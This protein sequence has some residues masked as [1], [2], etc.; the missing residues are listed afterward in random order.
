MLAKPIHDL[1]PTVSCHMRT[2]VALTVSLIL[3]ACEPSSKAAEPGSASAAQLAP[4]PAAPAP[5]APPP[6]AAPVAPPAP[7]VAAEPEDTDP[8]VNAIRARYQAIERALSVEP[9]RKLELTCNDVELSIRLHERDGL[10][11][12]VV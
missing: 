6:A 11:K 8:R 5:V 1:C 3:C 12:A 10:E 2:A 7:A 4:T 9:T